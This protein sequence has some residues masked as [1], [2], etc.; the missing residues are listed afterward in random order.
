PV[1]KLLPSL[2][3]KEDGAIKSLVDKPDGASHFHSKLKGTL[4]SIC[5]ILWHSFNLSFPS[6]ESTTTPNLLNP[7]QRSFSIRSRRGFAIFMLS[8][9]IPKV[10]YL[11]FIKP[12]F[13]LA[14]WL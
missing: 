13:P 10:R 4:P 6:I 5:K 11:L 1:L 2:N 14:S 12:L 3:S 8:A 7:F 9:S